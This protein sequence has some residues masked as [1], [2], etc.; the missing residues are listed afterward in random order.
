MQIY[1]IPFDQT[2]METTHHGSF[3]FPLAI[4]TTQIS[5][6]ILGYIDWHWHHELQFCVVTQGQVEF[7]VNQTRF[8]LKQGDGIFVN[9][10]QLHMARNLSSADSTYICLDLHPRLISGFM[11]SIVQTKYVDPYLKN[12]GMTD[13]LLQRNVP[14]QAKI[15]DLLLSIH[16][17]FHSS[18]RDEMQICIW[19]LMVWHT[20]ISSYADCLPRS[21]TP[22]ISPQV[23]KI[24]EYIRA[25]YASPITLDQISKQAALAKSTCCR[26]FK[27]QMG[28]TIFDHILNVRLQEASRLLLTSNISITEVSMRCGFGNSSYFT[29]EFRLKTGFSPSAYRKEKRELRMDILS[30]I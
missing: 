25:N 29:K 17:L 7:F 9:T 26:E 14:W 16:K 4:Y 20:F 18:E 3:A 13:C 19:L 12:S 22:S 8:I 6:N 1:D 11:G 23:R 10:E 15:L 30:T 2:H 28:Y 27:K 5:K 24:L 21:T